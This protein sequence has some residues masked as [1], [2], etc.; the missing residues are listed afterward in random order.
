MS[1]WGL[2]YKGAE[3]VPPEEWNSV[4]DALNELDTRVIGGKAIF[5]GDGTTRIFTI[6]HG[7][8]EEPLTVIVGKGAPGLPD[9]DYWTADTVK[10]SVVFKSPPL[11]GTDIRIWWIAVKVPSTPSE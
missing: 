1:R 5:I 11:S 9:I 6:P 7:L 2:Y 8:N 3:I 4:I 10:I